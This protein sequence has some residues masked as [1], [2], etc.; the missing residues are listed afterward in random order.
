MYTLVFF[1]PESHKEL[2]KEAIFSAGA[3]KF[4]G[5]E[6]CSW[7]TLGTGQFRPLSGCQPFIGESG[8]IEQVNEYRVETICTNDTI[9]AA[10]SALKLAHPYEEPA[11]QYWPVNQEDF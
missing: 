9:K 2:V 4:D 10:V 5:Y 6:F 7:E 3:G 8:K 1:V 11:Y